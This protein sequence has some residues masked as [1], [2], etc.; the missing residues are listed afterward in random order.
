MKANRNDSCP[1]GSGKKYKKCCQDKTAPVV[2]TVSVEAL[3][4]SA[5]AAH[6]RG[7][8]DAAEQGYGAVL[9]QQPKQVDALHLLGVVCMQRGDFRA[10]IEFIQEA[11]RHGGEHRDLIYNLGNALRGAR[12]D[13]EAAEAYRRILVHSPQDVEALNNLGLALRGAG[14][15]TEALACFEQALALAPADT[16]VMGNVGLVLSDINRGDEAIAIYRKAL[17]LNPALPEILNNLGSALQN[18]GDTV[19][20][21]QAYRQALAYKPTYAE[22]HSNLIF[23]MDFVEEGGVAAQQAER[24]RWADTYTADI[25]PYAHFP[26]VRDAD[27]KLRIGYVSPDFRHHS[28][29]YAY[30]PLILSYDR[31]RFDVYCYSN[32]PV[33][34]DLTQRF[35]QSATQWRDVYALN[36]AQVAS[37]IRGDEID[38]LVDL[39]GHSRNN[40]LGVMAHRP[41]PIQASGWGHANGTGLRTVDYLFSDPVYIPPEEQRFFREKILYLPCVIGYLARPEAPWEPELPALRNGHVTF[42]SFS[43]LAKVS[44]E[45]LDVW[46]KLLCE[47]PESRILFK[48]AELGSP[49]RCSELLASMQARGVD[50]ARITLMPGTSWR[51]HVQAMAGMDI[52]LDPY[53]HGGGISIL[54]GLWMGVPALAIQRP[55]PA[56]RVAASVLKAHSLGDWVAE[57]AEE[58]LTIAKAKTADLASLAALR[59]ELRERV[60]HSPVGDA[61]TYAAAVEKHY[62]SAWHAFIQSDSGR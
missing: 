22:A 9:A 39:A 48:A 1:C 43:R 55:M 38:I 62:Q 34:D 31:E 54:D 12:R 37:Q 6:Q 14:Q 21:I 13:M 61:R 30:A 5:I 50:P 40:R 20:A 24:A 2:A 11:I 58:F 57:T 41:A 29:A 3:L 46:A 56:G 36:D 16:D 53:P 4:D 25:A 35:R 28:A 59:R 26:N 18:T 51:E 47:L 10:A 8:L 45:V 7:E 17:A 15:S 23:S 19:A 27:R 32:T 42:G 60:A 44:A 52:A 49:G 33:V